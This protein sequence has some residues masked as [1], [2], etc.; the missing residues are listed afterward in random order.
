MH[1]LWTWSFPEVFYRNLRIAA[2]LKFGTTIRANILYNRSITLPD[3][4]G[5]L[6]GLILHKGLST[7]SA[8]YI[9]IIK[10]VI[11]LELSLTISVT[12]LLCIYVIL[13]KKHVMERQSMGIGLD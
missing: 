7:N 4:E 10:D 1:K 5:H 11:S 13:K 8:H 9:S 3:F 12:I 6:I 2:K